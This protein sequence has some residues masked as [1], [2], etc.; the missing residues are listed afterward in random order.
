M[1]PLK[2][3]LRCLA[4]SLALWLDGGLLTGVVRADDANGSAS[5]LL[6]AHK[7]GDS[8]G[9]YDAATGK[10]EQTVA[11]GHRPHE[12]ALSRDRKLAYATLYGIDLYTE[13]VEGGR[14]IAVVDVAGRT[15]RGEIDLGKYRRPHGIEIGH[16]TDLLYVTCDH[17]AALLVIDPM[18][19]KVVAGIELSKANSL[20]HMVAVAADEQTA[21]VANCGTADISVI[22]L[23]S[24]REVQR[25]DVGGIPMGMALT[26][27]GRTL[28]ATTRTANSLA[29]ID[30]AS[31]KVKRV[32]EIVGQPVRAHATPDGNWVLTT[33]IDSGELAVVDAQTWM[34]QRRIPIGRRVEG[35]T[36]DPEGRFAY[37]SAQADD[38]IARVSLTDW[39][40][41]AEISAGPR[42]DPIVVLSR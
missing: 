35:L 25:I 18:K 22:D 3:L 16:K 39:K 30:V 11:V 9:F 19:S 34:L 5:K 33:L 13:T 1:N 36:V 31:R 29:V 7:W 27:D 42:P 20:C 12:L 37:A 38:K 4:L 23:D 24:R 40:V 28:F 15:K 26:V 10:L 2:A 6:V 21:F 17:P 8:V 41:V 14:S 32:I